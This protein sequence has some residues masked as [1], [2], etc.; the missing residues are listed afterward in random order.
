MNKNEEV[1]I[2][3]KKH[4]LS[5]N[6][7]LLTPEELIVGYS[8]NPIFYSIDTHVVADSKEDIE[9]NESLVDKIFKVSDLCEAYDYNDPEFVKSYF[10][11]EEKNQALIIDTSNS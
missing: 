10:F 7:Y 2:R 3:Y 11:E 8:V 9:A 5:D 4:R 1:A 6:L